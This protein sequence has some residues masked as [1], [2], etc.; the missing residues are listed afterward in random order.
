MKGG[1][2][3]TRNGG[4]KNSLLLGRKGK[5]KKISIT[6][7][8]PEKTLLSEETA[9]LRD[10]DKRVN[11]QEEKGDVVVLISAEKKGNHS[12]MRSSKG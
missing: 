7:S 9:C 3:G 6:S 12:R 10:H 4:R 5:G 2:G 11:P 8:M 1:G